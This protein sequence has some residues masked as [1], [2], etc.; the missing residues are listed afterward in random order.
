MNASELLCMRMTG[1][2]K[3]QALGGKSRGKT[4]PE[5]KPDN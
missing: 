4:R 1:K 3:F 5:P 2:G